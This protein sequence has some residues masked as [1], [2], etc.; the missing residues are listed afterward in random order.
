MSDIID[1]L[2]DI[3]P[4][5]TI[6]QSDEL[7]DRIWP[8]FQSYHPAAIGTALSNMVAT[9]LI[10]FQ[11]DF[12][13]STQQREELLCQHLD[14]VHKLVATWEEGQGRGH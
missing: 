14:I 6:R 1:M 4:E 9:W 7:A 12:G 3:S 10:N 11:D 2:P 8:M 13:A 5:E